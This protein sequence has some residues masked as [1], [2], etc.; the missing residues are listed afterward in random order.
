MLV[1]AA[2]ARGDGRAQ[3]DVA[4]ASWAS[5]SSAAVTGTWQAKSRHT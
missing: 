5:R 1:T 4:P 3:P 2:V